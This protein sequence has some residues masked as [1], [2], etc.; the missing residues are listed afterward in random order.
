MKKFDLPLWADTFFIFCIGFLFFFCVFRFYTGTLWGAL[1]AAAAAAAALT[2]LLHLFLKK[3][4]SRKYAAAADKLEVQK[5]SFHLAMD[6]PENN[7]RRIAEALAAQSG[8]DAKTEDGRILSDGKEY[9]LLFRL[10]PATADELAAI[11]R[12][13]GGEKAAMA[14]AFTKDAEKLAL[15][16]GIELCGA[17]KVY[18][19]L[20]ETD[21]LPETYIMGNQIRR[22]LKNGIRLRL[23]RKSWR[24][25]LLA[26]ASLLLF[27]LIS[28]FP[29]YYIAAGG[30]LLAAAVLVRIFGKTQ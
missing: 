12:R 3:R 20:K 1:S 26:G 15:S 13:G 8:K 22:S 17:E 6:A 9:F 18:A 25:Y 5:L 2:F 19:L 23:S 7:L 16:F 24:G 4:R 21:K 27:S 11:V 29:V 10:E 14:S 28:I 30:L